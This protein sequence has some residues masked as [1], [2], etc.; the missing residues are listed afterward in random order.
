MNNFDWNEK[1]HKTLWLVLIGIGISLVLLVLCIYLGTQRVQ[2]DAKAASTAIAKEKT[3]SAQEIDLANIL[4]EK[5][6]DYVIDKEEIPAYTYEQVQTMDMSKPSGVTV[7][8]LKLVTR[9]KLVGTEK[10]LYQMEQDYNLNCLFLL[11]VA[12]HESAYGTSQFHKNNVCGYGY[13]DYDSIDDCLDIV[14]RVLAKNYLDPDGPYYKGT[15][16]DSVNKT[17][18]ADP[19]WDSKVA[20]KVAYF[21]KV[22]SEN[23]NKQLEKLK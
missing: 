14:G 10:K 2:S 13:S 16:I 4:R 3:A 11:G 20:R 17:Y 5:T 19:A 12:S 22:I 9:Y 21:Y 15:T 1:S 23:H 18:A 6:V 8:D 7:A